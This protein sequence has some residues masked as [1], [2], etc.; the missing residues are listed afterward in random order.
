MDAS[1]V[2]CGI[3][4]VVIVQ[5][6]EVFSPTRTGGLCQWHY[7]WHLSFYGASQDALGRVP[8]PVALG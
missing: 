7:H 1:H 8:L 4:P 5:Q 2:R 3:Q 6:V